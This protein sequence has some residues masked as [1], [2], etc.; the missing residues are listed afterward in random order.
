MK[1]VCAWCFPDVSHREEAEQVTHGICPRHME[2]IRQ[3]AIA[4]WRKEGWSNEEINRAFG[5]ELISVSLQAK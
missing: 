3:D 5:S 2:T 1:S 4:Y